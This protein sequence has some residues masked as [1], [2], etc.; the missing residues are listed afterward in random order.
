MLREIPTH[1]IG[2]PL[3]AG[4]TS[5]IRA[6]LAQKPGGERWAVLVNEF[7]EIGLDAAL[8]A[9]QADGVAIGEV[10]GGCL[11][12][13]N[14]VPFQV[15][16][17]RLL[18]RARPDRLFIEPSG[19]GH[20]LALWKQLQA[21]PWAGVLALQPPVLVLDAA[22]LAAGEPLPEAQEQALAVAGLV[23]L[24]KSEALDAAQRATATARLPAVPV[25]WGVGGRLALADLPGGA[26]QPRSEA[27][28]AALP[29]APAELPL[30]LCADRPLRAVREQDGQLAIGWRLAPSVRFERAG[31]EAW[32]RRLSGLRR[33]KAVLRCADGWYA[34]NA[35]PLVDN[36]VKSSWRRDNRLE[37]I[38]EPGH[39]EE[40]LERAFLA[41]R[42]V[43]Q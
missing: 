42:M 12:C 30:L 17:G 14:G 20:P 43:A 10:A 26:P 39:D 16:L 35:A 22:A 3:G 33:A 13:V 1:L 9:T 36:W 5:L 34:V 38:L 29:D 8:L 28:S 37:L 40:A 25:R 23:L 41:C 15:G 11:C 4:K 7:G 19:L 18:R 6:L 31:V 24:N 21:A 2:G 27:R 32:L